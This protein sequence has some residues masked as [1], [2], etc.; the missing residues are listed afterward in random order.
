VQRG[1]TAQFSETWTKCE[2]YIGRD[3]RTY[4]VLA[5]M[6]TRLRGLCGY[7]AS[8][9]L[10]QG[11]LTAVVPELVTKE[12]QICGRLGS[13]NASRRLAAKKFGKPPLS[14]IYLCV[15]ILHLSEN[16]LPGLC[17][18]TAVAS[19]LESGRHSCAL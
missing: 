14:K 19:G 7:W 2:H 11:R 3:I 12:D 16:Y 1:I 15:G 17:T 9:K 10:F 4:R 6:G 18:R 5:Q 8:G 13:K